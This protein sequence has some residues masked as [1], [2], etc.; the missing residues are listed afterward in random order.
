MTSQVK[1]RTDTYLEIEM[2][3]REQIGRTGKVRKQMK[4]K[5]I[6]LTTAMKYALVSDSPHSR[7]GMMVGKTKPAMRKHLR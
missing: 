1:W 6:H 4:G 5:S 3:P 2:R 7:L